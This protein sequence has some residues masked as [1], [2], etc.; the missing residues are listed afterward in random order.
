M[1]GDKP[2]RICIASGKGGT[3]KTLISTSMFYSLLQ[4]RVKA[5]LIDCDA[6]EPNDMLFFDGVKLKEKHVVQ[7]VPVIDENKCTFCGKCHDY[8]SYHAIFI[9]PSERM[10]QVTEDLCHGCGAC[11]VACKFDAITEKEVILGTVSHFF[12]APASGIVE[13]RTRLGVYSPVAVI[14]AAINAVEKDHAIVMDAPPGNS[15]SFIH[16]VR[17]ADYV[18]LVTEP[19]PFGLSDLKQSAEILRMMGKPFGVIINR[20]GTGN[21][22]TYHYVTENKIPLLMEI[23]F[24]RKIASRYAMGKVLASTDNTFSD[25][26]FGV[27]NNI[28]HQHGNS[29]YQRE[30]RNR[31]KQH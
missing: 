18:I 10:I 24:D 25:R 5:T 13:S 20:A 3:G 22:Q 27:F 26:L 7:R 1:K 8:C 9:L 31:E 30:G 11:L 29:H 21:M 12:I 2:I 17:K 14:N 28:L 19:T 16:T 15:C 6:E 4:H 23:P